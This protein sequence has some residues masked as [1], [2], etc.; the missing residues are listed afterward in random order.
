[1]LVKTSAFM[2]FVEKYPPISQIFIKTKIKCTETHQTQSIKLLLMV[3]I[4]F[5]D[6]FYRKKSNIYYILLFLKMAFN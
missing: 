5:F 1:M 6:I 2:I 4:M 3:K